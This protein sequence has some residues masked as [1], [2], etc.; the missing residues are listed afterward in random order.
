MV[1]KNLEH[2]GTAG[3]P[4][5]A[6]V[7]FPVERNPGFRRHVDLQRGECTPQL[8]NIL[9]ADASHT[10]LDQRFTK[11]GIGAVAIAGVGIMFVQEFAD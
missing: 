7:K 4:V 9:G 10:M 3:E 1:G 6:L 2:V 11:V 5:D 8:Y